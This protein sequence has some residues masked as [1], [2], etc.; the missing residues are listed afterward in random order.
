MNVLSLSP[1]EVERLTSKFRVGDGC[2]EW[3][4]GRSIYG[5]GRFNLRHHNRLAHAVVY[6]WLA[7]PV[8]E[9]LVLDHLC[10]NRGCV[11]PDHLE[12]VT[13]QTNIL[14]GVGVAAQYAGRTHCSHGHEFTPE[15][16]GFC[17]A[18]GKRARVCLTCRK[19]RNTAQKSRRR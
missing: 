13:N 12:A 6:E 19:I 11:R 18:W 15:N 7:G 4:A 10:R 1:V 2:W 17:E 16:T 8:P 14:R 5:Y 9:G 3:T